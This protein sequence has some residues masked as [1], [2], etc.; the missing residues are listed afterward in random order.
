MMC[1]APRYDQNQD[2]GLISPPSPP[3]IRSYL[4]TNRN[5]IRLFKEE[6]HMHRVHNFHIL[7]PMD[8]QANADSETF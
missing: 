1:P 5:E 3:L 2:L 4:I 7:Y 8:A 6:D